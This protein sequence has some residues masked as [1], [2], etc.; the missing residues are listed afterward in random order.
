MALAGMT[1]L[2]LG[3]G[4][5]LFRLVRKYRPAAIPLDKHLFESRDALHRLQV[6]L[7]Q[8]GHQDSE[9]YLQVCRA[10]PALE[11]ECGRAKIPAPGA[12]VDRAP[13]GHKPLPRSPRLGSEG[14]GALHMLA[15]RAA[16]A[17]LTG[18]KTPAASLPA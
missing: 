16:R 4:Y 3:L 15:A 8:G 14:A 13:A 12:K 5:L 18:D 2:A 10:L 11:R 7:E 9:I 17:A 1:A 6:C